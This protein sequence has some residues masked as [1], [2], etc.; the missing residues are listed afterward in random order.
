MRGDDTDR[1]GKGGNEV[2]GSEGGRLGESK[3]TGGGDGI[4]IRIRIG[5]RHGRG[6][7]LRQW[8]ERLEW[9]RIEWSECRPVGRKYKLVIYYIRTESSYWVTAVLVLE[10]SLNNEE[11]IWSR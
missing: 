2:V 5:E 7:E 4:R 10:K 11:A 9:G 6:T 1:R 8:E 3:R